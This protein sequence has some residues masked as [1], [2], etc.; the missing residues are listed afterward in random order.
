VAQLLGHYGESGAVY[1]DGDPDDDGDVDLSDLAAL[2]GVYGTVCE[3]PGKVTAGADVRLDGTRLAHEWCYSG[4]G[5]GAPNS[6][7]RISLVG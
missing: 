3:Q 5:A 6:P 1:E 7:T 4:R 2:L